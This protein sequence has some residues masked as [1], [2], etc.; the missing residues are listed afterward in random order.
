VKEGGTSLTQWMAARE[1]R[2]LGVFGSKLVTD[3]V[4]QLDV[5]LLGVLLHSGDEGPG[6][7][8]GGLCG[9]SCIGPI[10]SPLA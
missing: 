3:A 7:G 6:H 10:R 2:L 9:N 5:A 8:T 1:L 4:Q